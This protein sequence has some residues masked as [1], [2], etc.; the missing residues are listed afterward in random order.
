MAPSIIPLILSELL[1]DFRLIRD[2]PLSIITSPELFGPPFTNALDLWYNV[3]GGE[4]AMVPGSYRS[5]ESWLF[6]AVAIVFAALD[7]VYS[8]IRLFSAGLIV[9]GALC[10]TIFTTTWIYITV[11][12]RWLL[13]EGVIG[14]LN[15]AMVC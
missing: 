7:I 13:L 2:N 10:M 4:T 14:P 6:L 1:T 15:L 11:K 9:G 8:A 12:C 3:T 5:P